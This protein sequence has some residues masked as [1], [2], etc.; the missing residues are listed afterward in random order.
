MSLSVTA[1]ISKVADVVTQPCIQICR[2]R[3]VIY[4]AVNHAQVP[5][6]RKATMC[7][8]GITIHTA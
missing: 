3:M 6:P 5:N 8:Q 7:A 4:V 2:L 1:Q